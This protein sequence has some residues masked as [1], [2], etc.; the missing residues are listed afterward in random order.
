MPTVVSEFRSWAT[1]QFMA[2]TMFSGDCFP[3]N[4]GL[5][6]AR[7][8]DLIEKIEGEA[9]AEKGLPRQET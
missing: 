4:I 9:T 8:P 1:S 7:N 6:A 2:I 5:G 3:A